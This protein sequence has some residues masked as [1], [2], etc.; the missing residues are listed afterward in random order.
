MVQDLRFALRTL[1]RSPGFT[2]TAALT[3]ALGIGVTTLMFGVVNAVLLRPLPYPDQDRLML[4][5]NTSINAPEVNTIRAS[6]LDFEDYRARAR[7]FEAIAAHVGTGF[8]FTGGGDPELVI[9][10]LVTPDF[11]K[12]IGVAPAAGRAFA[13]DE[14]SP[15]RENVVI[16]SHGLWQ[17]RFGGRMS[18]IGS[19]VTINGK[20]WTVAGVM[21]RG[22]DYPSPRCLLYTSP[23]PRDS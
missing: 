14:F 18:T 9:G 6:A 20:P 5:F 23:S 3:L 4:V 21:P 1:L 10:Q 15:G 22:F 2:L 19:T 17:R 16:L 7:T 12:V 8:T 11:F 13:P